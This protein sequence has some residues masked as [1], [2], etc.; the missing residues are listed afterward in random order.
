LKRTKIVIVILKQK[1]EN[2]APTLIEQVK[3][4][5]GKDACLILIATLLSLRSRDSATLEVCRKL[6]KVIR[7][8]QE[9]LKLS[10]ED[11]Q[12]LIHSIGFYKNKSKT[13]LNVS[14]VII[15]KFDGKVPNDFDALIAIKGIGSKTANLVLAE[16]FDIPTICVDVHVHRISNRLGIIKTKTTAETEKALQK[17]ISKKDWSNWN[18]LLVKWGQNICTPISPFCSKCAIKQ[19]CK[20]VGVKKFR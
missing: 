1:T 3:K 19:Y 16:A 2:F 5:F 6:F 15:E 12:F 10:C 7:S 18:N 13:I 14:K 9:M 8:P 4:E 20:Q 11:L 17:I